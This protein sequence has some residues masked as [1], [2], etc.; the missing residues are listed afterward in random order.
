MWSV[1]AAGIGAALMVVSVHNGGVHTL[2]ASWLFLLPAWL[3]RARTHWTRWVGLEY[4]PDRLDVRV[5]RV[6]LRFAE[7]A[8][9]LWAKSLTS[10]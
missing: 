8:G 4:R 7:A 3:L 1:L 6:H 2:D 10:L 9:K 5:T